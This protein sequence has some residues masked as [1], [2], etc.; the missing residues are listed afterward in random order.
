MA[1]RGAS[2]QIADDPSRATQQTD[3][4]SLPLPQVPGSLEDRQEIEDQNRQV[5]IRRRIDRRDR[6]KHQQR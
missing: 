4:K 2:P 1:V 5:T 6:S 3:G